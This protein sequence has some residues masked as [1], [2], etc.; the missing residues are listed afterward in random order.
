M[1]E[2]FVIKRMKSETYITTTKWDLT[3]DIGTTDKREDACE[4]PYKKA[5]RVVDIMNTVEGYP[6]W[7]YSP[8]KK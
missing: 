4:L 7:T 2:K 8:V 1:E 3:D 5:I 6:T